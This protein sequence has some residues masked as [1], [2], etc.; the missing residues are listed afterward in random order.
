MATST[1]EAVKWT[2]DNLAEVQAFLRPDSPLFNHRQAGP[3]C[4]IGLY[5]VSNKSYSPYELQFLEVGDW[6]VQ[7]PK[8]FRI[9]TAEEF[10]A[11]YEIAVDETAYEQSLHGLSAEDAA[12]IRAHERD[13]A[14][15]YAQR[16]I[17]RLEQIEKDTEPGRIE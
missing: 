3:S 14:F 13:P 4:L 10:A 16:T 9:M 12:Q 1:I 2:G 11:H 6:I 7:L 15:E 17:D 8:G 5:V